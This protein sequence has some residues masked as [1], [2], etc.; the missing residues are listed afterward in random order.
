MV[1]F[2]APFGPTRCV[3]PRRK[4]GVLT[5]GPNEAPD[6]HRRR[7]G[8]EDMDLPARSNVRD[9]D[10]SEEA[11]RRLRPKSE[12][13]ERQRVGHVKTTHHGDGYTAQARAVAYA[14]VLP[15]P[16]AGKEEGRLGLEPSFS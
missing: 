8:P 1:D 15:R 4:T 5:A 7:F 10:R 12:G 3:K 14:V 11:A 16:T 6:S 13:H 9:C 2:P